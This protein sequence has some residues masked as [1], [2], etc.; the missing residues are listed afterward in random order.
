M[1]ASN[2]FETNI[3]KLVLQNVDYANVG[4][5]GGIRGSAV[6]GSLWFSL[7]TADPGEAGT[8]VTNEADY[9]SYARVAAARSSSGFNVASGVG[10][11]KN[12]VDWPTC[13]GGSNHIT[14]FGIVSTASG[15]GILLFSGAL[16][17]AIDVSN[18]ITPS[19]VADAL[20][21]TVD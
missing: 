20:T 11:N 5:A 13:T 16:A 9:T 1:S 19:A 2:D 21:V 6:A 3:L 4:D 7:H 14:H 10:S 17:A 18:L 12:Q 15:A 8:A